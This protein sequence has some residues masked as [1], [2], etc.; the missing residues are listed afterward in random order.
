MFK[1]YAF[2]KNPAL[3]RW[4]TPLTIGTFIL[5][6]VTGVLMFFEQ[7]SLGLITVAHQWFSWLFILGI[8]GHV[9]SNF[10]SFKTHFKT[11]WGK[12]SVAL[13]TLIL[14][15]SFYSWGMITGPQLERPIERALVEASLSSLALV[16]NT[17]TEV[18]IQKLKAHGI[19]ADGH[20]SLHD[21]VVLN[22]I[23]E[24]E[25]LGLVFLSE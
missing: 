15:A 2:L 10:I 3:R 14:L 25:L 5:M 7:E 20:Q 4:S 22:N 19:D 18:L 9:V 13:F 6:L 17:D 23:D 8:V 24:N 12:T 1:S 16:T 11:A 21:L